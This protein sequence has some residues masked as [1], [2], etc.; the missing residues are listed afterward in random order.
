MNEQ[1]VRQTATRLN[2]AVEAETR[3]A[4]QSAIEAELRDLQTSF[5]TEGQSNRR[6][7]LTQGL[8][9]LKAARRKPSTELVTLE[10]DVVA[11]LVRIAADARSGQASPEEKM[12]AGVT[13]AST[14]AR[15]DFRTERSLP[16]AGLGAVS[17]FVW[18][19]RDSFGVD[20]S[21]VGELGFGVGAGAV[22]LVAAEVLVLAHLAQR[23][24]E[25]VLRQLYATGPQAIALRAVL[26]AEKFSAEQYKHALV[27]V[28]SQR[29]GLSESAHRRGSR[30]RKNALSTVDLEAALDDS[31]ELALMRFIQVGVIEP[32]ASWSGAEYRGTGKFDVVPPKKTKE[33]RKS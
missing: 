9:E 28:A 32:V 8:V 6:R 23:R 19:Q 17:L 25:R 13:V 31:G 12:R 29:D 4:L 30:V 1:D 14:Q 22:L 27:E 7:E 15:K 33:R 20:L 11:D 26:D 18:S 5:L 3:Q 24:D 10:R 2:I 16:F 21:G